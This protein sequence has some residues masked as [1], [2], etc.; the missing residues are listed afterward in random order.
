MTLM[1]NKSLQAT[2]VG[3][4][5]SAVAVRVFGLRVPELHR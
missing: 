1:P 3:A 4:G 2:R 5:S